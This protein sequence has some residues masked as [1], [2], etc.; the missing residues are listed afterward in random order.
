MLAYVYRC[1]LFK[2]NSSGLLS[3]CHFRVQ[4]SSASLLTRRP[5][6]ITVV[7]MT[8]TEKHSMLLIIC[9]Q[10]LYR[11]AYFMSNKCFFIFLVF[12]LN[13]KKILCICALDKTY[14]QKGFA[15]FITQ[16]I[17]YISHLCFH[18]ACV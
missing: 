11:S 16:A 7:G 1:V 3:C 5:D 8:H 9:Q 10:K 4:T 14:W 12:I 2:R 18:S 6:V 17:L 13:F 15:Y